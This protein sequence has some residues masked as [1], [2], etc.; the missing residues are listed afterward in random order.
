VFAD[1]E[2]RLLVEAAG[3]ADALAALVARRAAGEP[4]EHLLGWAGFAGLRIAVG[5]G[6]F[7]PRRRSELLV[8]LAAAHLAAAHDAGH[9]PAVVLDLCCGSGA[10]GAGIAH[11]LAPRGWRADD[12][13]VVAC[14]LD[15]AAADCARR[16]LAPWHGEVAVGDLFD[17]VPGTLRGRVDALVANA[18]YVPTDSIAFM[19]PEARDHEPRIALD[20]GG[21]GLD[22]HRRIAAGAGDWLRAGG[23]LV[24]EV[25]ERQVPQ[26]LEAMAGVGLDPRT[27]EDED[28][29]AIA[30]VGTRPR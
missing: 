20:G 21:D 9:A 29:G 24:I 5:P 15:P 26:A 13:R 12:L 19:P 10:L 22:L 6:V 3:T 25:S 30:V 8:R 27:E 2:A 18:P 7:V 4:L 14:D 1:E 16:N 23:V 11:A 28:L 17:A